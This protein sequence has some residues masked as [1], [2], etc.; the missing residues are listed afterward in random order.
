[1]P[2]E[3]GKMG[4]GD[5]CLGRG[6]EDAV[7]DDWRNLMARVKAWTGTR[8]RQAWQKVRHLFAG[9]AAEHA[10]A[11]PAQEAPK[12]PD[13]VRQP[14]SVAPAAAPSSSEHDPPILRVEMLLG[15]I[16]PPSPPI[17]GAPGEFIAGSFTN[18]AGTRAYKLHVPRGPFTQALP[19]L[20]MLHGCKQDP[21]DFAAGTRMNRLAD[22]GGW[23][24]L[25][26]GQDRSV[27]AL[28]CWNWFQ[29]ADQQRGRGEPSIIADMT[30]HVIATQPVDPQRVYVAGLS[31]GGAMAAIMAT[32]Y[33]ELY[34]AAGIHSG[35]PHAAANDL[36]SALRAMKRGPSPR[37]G[38]ADRQEQHAVPTI[39]FHGDH[40]TTV[41][42]VNGDE[43]IARA[44]Y[45]ASARPLDDELEAFTELV[46]VEQGEVPGGHAFS[47]TLHRDEQGRC[48]AEHWV[49]HGAGHAWSGGDP[50][51]SYTDPA[52]PDASKEML[53]FFLEHPRDAS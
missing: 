22:T 45:G 6:H 12:V 39:V 8:S 28:G 10:V 13:P 31:A 43:V 25:Y 18:A 53:R 40:D 51:G 9:K 29:E 36:V 17:E 42:P 48:D 34:A 33:P 52:G 23:I 30:R 1:M 37:G 11:E 16:P 44:R 5:Q 50:S 7:K 35:L 47:R 26:P 32:T 49:I 21:D 38:E 15:D 46:A 27:N 2:G 14:S 20:V 41:H 4:R 19:L 24:V 3:C